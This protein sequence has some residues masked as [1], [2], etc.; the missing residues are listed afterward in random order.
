MVDKMLDLLRSQGNQLRLPHSHPLGDG[1]FELRFAIAHGRVDQ[2]ITYV[3]EP[4]RRIITLTT[5]RKTRRRETR[6]IT[7]ARRTL[8]TR[9]QR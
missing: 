8:T 4:V 6:E 7:R 1:L 9:R 3:F 5:F 2:R